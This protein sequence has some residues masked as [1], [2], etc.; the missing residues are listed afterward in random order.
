MKIVSFCL[1]LISF[2]C[3]AF[4]SSDVVTV[5]KDSDYKGTAQNFGPGKHNMSEFTKSGGVGNDTIS[6]L[7]VKK[8]Y[9]VTLYWDSNF[10]GETLTF[11]GDVPFVGSR[12]NDKA[13]SLVV[14]KVADDDPPVTVYKDADFR[15]VAQSFGVGKHN[16]KELQETVGN[17]SISSIKVKQGYKVTLYA[18]ANF[19][20]QSLALTS[21]NYNFTTIK[22]PN[23][24]NAN[25]KI[26]S[27]IVEKLHDDND[28]TAVV[29][30][31]P[32]VN[33]GGIGQS[34][35]IGRHDSN[36]LNSLFEN[37]VVKSLKVA[38][39]Y[40]VVFYNSAMSVLTTYTSS[41]GSVNIT[42][43]KAISVQKSSSYHLRV[44]S[45]TSDRGWRQYLTCG[46]HD[47]NELSQ[48]I[49][50]D[51]RSIYRY[52]GGY[53]VEVV[54]YKTDGTQKIVN[55]DCS[56]VG[57]D[58]YG[59]VDHI[60]VRRRNLSTTAVSIG[61]SAYFINAPKTLKEG[62]YNTVSSFGLG[63]GKELKAIYV[64]KGFTVILFEKENMPKA[65][66]SN[67]NCRQM[68]L[69]AMDNYLR[70]DDV[71]AVFGKVG[72]IHVDDLKTTKIKK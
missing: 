53:P 13:S 48:V 4:G 37:G 57:D 20:G 26:S 7:K 68:A 3:F 66:V 27:L 44:C 51:I 38:P 39:G 6:S 72:S 16:M 31:Y 50:K 46:K 29:T 63:S 33:Y 70:I 23:G 55:A 10:N 42:G 17:D 15:G 28:P 12:F 47:S 67:R 32:A 11:T 1:C 8:G 40:R 9:K 30:I 35:G 49:G 36:E 59:K 41:S 56:N 22:F 14:E 71:E 45:D 18:D 69:C 21:A 54:F 24:Q 62:D 43:V 34:F 2:T 5:Y 65:A 61:D 19:S 25:D 60:E 64:P 52:T 58:L